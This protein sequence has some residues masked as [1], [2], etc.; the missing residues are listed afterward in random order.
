VT[1]PKTVTD[2]THP[3][4]PSPTIQEVLCEI[5][6]PVGS[7]PFP[8]QF[9]QVWDRLRT[10]FPH[11]EAYA[12]VLPPPILNMITS[13]QLPTQ[14]RFVLRHASRQILVQFTP[15][16][17]TLN[18]LAPYLGWETMRDDIEMAWRQVQEV[19]AVP[20][21][22]NITVR[23]INR[24]PLSPPF[25]PAQ[26]WLEAGDYV[27]AA[28]INA[29]PPFQSRIQTG[30]GIGNSTTLAIG[31]QSLDGNDLAMIVD[32]ERTLAGAFSSDAAEVIRQAD[33]LHTDIWN[34]FKGIKG[35]RWNDILEGKL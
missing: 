28:V 5:R 11:L 13:G 7:V 35:P 29:T 20:S 4:Y 30:I 10:E 34:L 21:V 12:D 8:T 19:L 16:A 15:G 2:N 23:Y 17:F 33:A 25:E 31:H 32:L 3:S 27:P 1:Q 14:P 9:G 24:V 26:G 22:S 6:F 18:T